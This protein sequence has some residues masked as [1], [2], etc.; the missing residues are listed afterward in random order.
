MNKGYNTV[1]DYNLTIDKFKEILDENVQN[2]FV[3]VLVSLREMKVLMLI[4]LQE[5]AGV[6]IFDAL[7]THTLTHTTHTQH[8]HTY[9]IHT[10]HKGNSLLTWYIKFTKENK[11]ISR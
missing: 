11:V 3:V 10:Q 5:A 1:Q 9:I 8:T 7:H 2:I 6:E 4:L